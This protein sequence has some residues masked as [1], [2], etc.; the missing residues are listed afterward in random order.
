[1]TSR[2][3]A[4]FDKIIAIIELLDEGYKQSEIANKLGI[5]KG[6][7]SKYIKE[8]DN[9]KAMYIKSNQAEMDNIVLLDRVTDNELKLMIV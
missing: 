8:Y 7:V 3:Q 9:N 2:E 4:K 1:M 5:G 6:T